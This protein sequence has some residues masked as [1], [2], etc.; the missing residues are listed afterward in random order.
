MQRLRSASRAFVALLFVSVGALHFTHTGLFVHLMPP[1]LPLHREAVLVSGFFEI[2]GGVGL[3]WRPTRRAAGLGL[4]LLLA[5]VYIVN[6]EM[7]LHP[8]PMPDGTIVPPWAAWARLPLQ[9]VLAALVA[10]VARDQGPTRDGKNRRNLPAS[11][12]SPAD[13]SR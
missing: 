5:S 10:W 4:L 7:A 9:F 13:S 6:I 1:Y 2:A 12:S 8:R 3:L 11:S